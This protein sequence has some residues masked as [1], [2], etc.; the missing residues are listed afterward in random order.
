MRENLEMT[1]GGIAAEPLYITLAALGHHDA[2]EKVRALTLKAQ[3]ENRSL[4]EV[5]V[6]DIEIKEYLVKMT[7]HQLKVFWDPSFYTGIASRKARAV[8]EWWKQKLAL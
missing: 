2:H 7:P 4:Q 8:A 6:K 5:A 1:K 3:E